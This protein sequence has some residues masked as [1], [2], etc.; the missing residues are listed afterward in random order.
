VEEQGEAGKRAETAPE[1]EEEEPCW[2]DIRRAQSDRRLVRI[3]R[4]LF[5]NPERPAVEKNLTVHGFRAS[6]R[7]TVPSAWAAASPPPEPEVEEMVPARAVS[8]ATERLL[9]RQLLGRYRTK[10]DRKEKLELARIVRHKVRHCLWHWLPTRWRGA[11]R[12]RRCWPA[13]VRGRWGSGDRAASPGGRPRQRQEAEGL[14][15]WL[16]RCPS[17]YGQLDHIHCKACQAKHRF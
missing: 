4:G 12:P 5:S 3:A 2:E 13:W 14:A 8:A 7:R 11:C 15:G 6:R 16:L 10:Y 9:L 17:F 1:W